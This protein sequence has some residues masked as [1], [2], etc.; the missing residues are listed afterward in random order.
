[1]AGLAARALAGL[2][3]NNPTEG[4]MASQSLM[5]ESA[6]GWIPTR[7]ARARGRRNRPQGVSRGTNSN[8]TRSPAKPRSNWPRLELESAE[9]A[10]PQARER[11]AK[12]K[13]VKTGSAGDLARRWQFEAGEIV[14]QLQEQKA[15]VRARTGPIK[16]KG[17][18][19]S[20]KNRKTNW[21]LGSSVEKARSEELAR[22][23]TWEL[24]QSKLMKLK[25][26]Q[27]PATSR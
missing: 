13:Q 15:R 22:Q 6:R 5:V 4:D 26:M 8:K 16:V 7:P 23:A 17:R 25:R 9:R 24:E 21:E 27:D 18:S 12:F 19:S 20:T 14:A 10:I 3:R 2:D 11:Y 1:M